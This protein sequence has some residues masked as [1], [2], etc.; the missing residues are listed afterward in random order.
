LA[1]AAVYGLLAAATNS[2][3]PS[4]VLHAGGNVFSVFSLFSQGRSEWQLTAVPAPTIWQ[5][6]LDASFLANLAALM[7]VG[8]IA[9]L[10]YRGLFRTAG[11]A[12]LEST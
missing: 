10:A 12:K 8:A 4:M 3:Y 5:A 2:T 9:A 7:I 11:V 6:G 1:V